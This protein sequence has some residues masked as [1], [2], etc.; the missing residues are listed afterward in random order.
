[1]LLRLAAPHTDWTRLTSALEAVDSPVLANV[2][3]TLL[4]A[5]PPPTATDPVALSF[6]PQQ[7]GSLQRIGAALGLSLPATPIAADAHGTEWVTSPAERAAAIAAAETIIG[8]H[9]RRHAV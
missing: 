9:Q 4:A 8:A 7:A 6:T 1:M 2:V 5:A 3:R